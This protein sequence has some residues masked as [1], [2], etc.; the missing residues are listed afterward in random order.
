MRASL[1]LCGQRTSTRVGRFLFSGLGKGKEKRCVPQD[2]ML[3]YKEKK[4]E[5]TCFSIYNLARIVF[6]HRDI[7]SLCFPMATFGSHYVSSL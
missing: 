3:S 5:A 6:L 7:E 1:L 2:D 4:T